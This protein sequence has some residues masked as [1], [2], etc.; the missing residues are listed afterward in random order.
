MG[1]PPPSSSPISRR[2]GR[3]S[4]K[5]WQEF[6]KFG[7][8]VDVFVARKR[9]K[10]GRK[11]GFVR[12]LRIRDIVTM[13]IEL[14]NAWMER[15]KLKANLA[16]YGRKYA[17]VTDYKTQKMKS[18]VVQDRPECSND[19]AR[20]LGRSYANAVNGYIHPPTP[21]SPASPSAPTSKQ[22]P[23]VENSL[24]R[25]KNVDL[26]TI[27]VI[28][29]PETTEKLN[30]SLIGEVRCLQLLK[31]LHE[32]TSVEGL[33]DV[34][35]SYY[36]GFSVLLEF[37]SKMA[38][39]DYLILARATWSKW[40]R[41]LNIWSPEVQTM[42]RLAYL[43]IAGLPPHAWIPHV[44][45]DIGSIWGEVVIPEWC[46]VESHIRD[47]GKVVILT[48]KFNLINESVEVFIE[49]SRYQVMVIEDFNESEN[50]SPILGQPTQDQN[51]EY[52]GEKEADS[53]ESLCDFHIDGDVELEEESAGKFDSFK[54][55]ESTGKF[56]SFHD[57]EEESAGKFD[58]F[59]DEEEEDSRRKDIASS[60]V[61]GVP[62][63]SHAHGEKTDVPDDPHGGKTGS[64]KNICAGYHPRTTDETHGG[65]SASPKNTHGGKSA[66]PKNSSAGS[67]P[68]TPEF[69][70][71]S[72]QSW[73]LLV[74][75]MSKTKLFNSSGSLSNLNTNTPTQIITDTHSTLDPLL[76]KILHPHIPRKSSDTIILNTKL[77][78]PQKENIPDDSDKSIEL[79]EEEID[80]ST[81]FWGNKANRL[82]KM[83]R[84]LKMRKIHSPCKCRVKFKRNGDCCKH[85]IFSGE[86]KSNTVIVD[87]DEDGSSDSEI[88]IRS[89]NFRNLKNDDAVKAVR[90]PELLINEEV[91][92]MEE[93]GKA[94]GVDLNGC[95]DQ[96]KELV[97]EIGEK[98]LND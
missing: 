46:N 57:E 44:F 19:G 75:S 27:Q 59:H 25:I 37:R 26:H 47:S 63:E 58:S 35:V 20:S 50:L 49:D 74:G 88:L 87:R 69:P 94:I 11:F 33:N 3:K 24:P 73:P 91:M 8:V 42:N 65:K 40:F 9:N 95:H 48:Q 41:S 98:F 84:D 81:R 23:M 14:N 70:C 2:T 38:A 80:A 6:R 82:K 22:D 12:F 71:A 93:V 85:A 66:S 53:D 51:S 90:N 60:R 29:P 21:T 83:K 92:K 77:S 78:Q 89:S 16:K 67:H 97:T 31:N 7:S 18:I 10:L 1:R 15:F 68:R 43:K 76:G 4:I 13:E 54:D 30:R 72:I 28:P 45:S 96:P 86:I 32:F 39:K 52:A 79:A 5:L 61:H 56:D 55:E 62:D 36:G 64:P 17:K 34:I